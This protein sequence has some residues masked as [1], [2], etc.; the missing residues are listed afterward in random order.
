MYTSKLSL[1]ISDYINSSSL[2][3]KY[4]HDLSCQNY[5]NQTKKQNKTS[6]YLYNLSI[7]M[8]LVVKIKPKNKTEEL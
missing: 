8:I 6:P 4:L 2:Q 3:L 5:K 1:S 7:D